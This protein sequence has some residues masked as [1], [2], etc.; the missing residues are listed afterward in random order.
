MS[1]TNDT[2]AVRSSAA[3]SVSA[4]RRLPVAAPSFAVDVRSL[5]RT[6][7]W[8]K[9]VMVLVVPV[10][11]GFTVTEGHLLRL[12]LTMVAFCLAS[13]AVYVLNDIADRER[14]RRHPTK[15]LRPIAA[16][17]ISPTSAALLAALLVVV[18]GV[19]VALVIP[20]LA[21][22]LLGYFA[23]NVAYNLRLK[24]VSLMDS[25]CV[26]SGFLL[27]A[28]AGATAVMIVPRPWLLVAILAGS[29]VLV[30]GKRRA[31]LSRH[32]E[33]NLQRP[34]LGG[35][36]VEMLDHLVIA[37]STI[38]IVA[39]LAFSLPRSV[40]MAGSALSSVSA[41]LACLVLFR[42]LQMLLRGE[43]DEDPTRLLLHDRSLAYLGG[44]W[45]ALLV[46]TSVTVGSPGFP[47]SA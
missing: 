16:G 19:L 8:V 46:V 9:N 22:V 11:Q 29:L 21:P 2:I 4:R 20:D 37:V 38:A 47:L 7:Q 28:I 31:E 42:Y 39:Y 40:S 33:S 30:L 25:A 10:L 3:G 24:H 17:R 6:R 23:I 41:M 26:A 1:Q 44:S 34:A 12:A 15:C 14:D 45:L 27:R 43:A 36:T 13:S 32:E 35:Y 5:L 18:D